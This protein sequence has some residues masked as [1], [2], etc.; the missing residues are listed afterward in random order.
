MI[1]MKSKDI[2]LTAEI[3]GYF[4]RGLPDYGDA[5]PK[6]IKFQSGCAALRAFLEFAGIKRIILPA[7][8]CDSVIQTVVDYRS[9]QSPV[10]ES[11]FWISGEMV[12]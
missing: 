2:N 12:G 8:I 10:L 11:G 9:R 4:A 7:Y 3:G 1:A 6:E 5:F